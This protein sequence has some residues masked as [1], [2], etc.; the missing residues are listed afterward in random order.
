M[1][2]R[3]FSDAE[4]DAISK[5][6]GEI[7][8]FGTIDTALAVLKETDAKEH[9]ILAKKEEHTAHMAIHMQTPELLSRTEIESTTVTEDM[10]DALIG[11]LYARYIM[12]RFEMLGLI[13]K[14]G[15]RYI[16]SE[17]YRI[18]AEAVA[19]GLATWEEVEGL[20][21]IKNLYGQEIRI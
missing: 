18:L 15:R 8:L 7:N 1:T 12:S 11:R 17:E 10:M 9:N 19:R 20:A 21:T 2:R 6:A 5:A 3:T 14:N 4:M 16:S 13:R